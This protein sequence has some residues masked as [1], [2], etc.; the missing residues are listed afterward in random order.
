MSWEI[1]ARRAVF[2]YIARTASSFHLSRMCARQRS[3]GASVA[4]PRTRSEHVLYVMKPS[5]TFTP[6]RGAGS[7]GTSSGISTEDGSPDLA[8]YDSDVLSRI[9]DSGGEL[10]I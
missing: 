4:F 6:I 1:V 2:S 7:V 5:S 9:E 8:V 3:S 10:G